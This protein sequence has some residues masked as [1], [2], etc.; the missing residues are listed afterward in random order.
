MLEPPTQAPV[1]VPCTFSSGKFPR[2]QH[3]HRWKGQQTVAEPL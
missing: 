1:P 3:L 2:T